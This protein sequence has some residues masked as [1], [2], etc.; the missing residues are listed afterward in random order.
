[1]SLA[2]SL[3]DTTF[4]RD[5]LK[6]SHDVENEKNEEN[7]GGFVENDD[8]GFEEFY[9]D[10]DSKSDKSEDELSTETLR[11][12]PI[13]SSSSTLPAKVKRVF[14]KIGIKMPTSNVNHT[15]LYKSASELPGFK[16]E[17]F[18]VMYRTAPARGKD[19]QSREHDE[20]ISRAIKAM[21]LSLQ[22]TFGA[23]KKTASTRYVEIYGTY[24]DSEQKTEIEEKLKKIVKSF[25]RVPQSVQIVPM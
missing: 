14:R 23:T 15:A 18:K 21:G 24:S 9:P 12:V 19:L 16:E 8:D 11:V 22:F 25:Q 7:D 4:N 1:M 17:A 20:V 6:N 5:F 2:K 10:S 3:S 13:P